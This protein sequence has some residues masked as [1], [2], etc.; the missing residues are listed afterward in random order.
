[1]AVK[2]YDI[3]I[4]QVNKLLQTDRIMVAS[5]SSVLAIQKRRIFDRGQDA[6][7]S[8][9]GTYSK[10]PISIS[11]KKQA[12]QTGKTYFKGGYAEYHSLIGKGSS[13]VNL[14]A[15]DQMMMDYSVQVLGQKEYGLGFTNTFN[16]NKSEWNEEHFDKDIFAESSE[17]SMTF[18]KAFQFELNRIE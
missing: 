9:I 4:N 11:R 15:T 3:L 12:R 16:F 10:K 14:R 2:G 6:N 1:M 8:N 13:A 5:I 17:D 18:D 7:L